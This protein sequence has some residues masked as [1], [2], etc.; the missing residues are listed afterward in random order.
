MITSFTS[1]QEFISYTTD[2]Y[3]LLISVGDDSI[4]ST[5]TCLGYIAALTFKPNEIKFLS[6]YDGK[7]I[8]VG[9]SQYLV[10]PTKHVFLTLTCIRAEE[11]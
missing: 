10:S 9:S 11:I 1:F 4:L 5:N 8:E 2:H 3:Y 6:K 7:I